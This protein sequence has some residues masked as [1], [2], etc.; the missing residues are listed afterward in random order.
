[1]FSNNFDDENCTRKNIS[2]VKNQT[3]D[4]LFQVSV[5]SARKS[6]NQMLDNI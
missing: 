1:M 3:Q 4:K 5:E 2:K 6:L